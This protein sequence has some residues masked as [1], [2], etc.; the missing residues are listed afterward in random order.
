M[1]ADW[2]ERARQAAAAA[3]TRPRVALLLGGDDASNVV[4]SIEP[5]LAGRLR[6]AGL[7]LRMAEAGYRIEEQGDASLA[8]LARWLHAERVVTRWRGELLDVVDAAGRSVGVVERAVVRVLGIATQAVHLVGFAEGQSAHWVQQRAWDKSTDPGRWDT[9]MG[10][11]VT[12]GESIA[13]TLERETAEEAGLALAD[14]RRLE[15]SEPVTIR[16]PVAEG[17]MIERIEVFRAIVP[18]GVE[19]VNRDGEVERFECLDEGS[20]VARLRAGE[21]TLEAT[22]VLGA[23]LERRDEAAGKS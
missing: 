6:A 8:A 9:L 19:P 4:G 21:F 15:R 13:A 18:V 17:Y 16:R 14:L 5:G 7:P 23:E 10:G 20:L 22:L 11:Q 1:A 2:L 3:P 12:A